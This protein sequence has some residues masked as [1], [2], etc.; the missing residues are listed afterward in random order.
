MLDEGPLRELERL[1][2]YRSS[3]G[4]SGA[5]VRTLF[6]PASFD[7]RDLADEGLVLI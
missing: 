2:K 5:L 6:A 4:I 7:L 1:K 3:E